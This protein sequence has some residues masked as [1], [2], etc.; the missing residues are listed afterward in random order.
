[1]IVTTESLAGPA[2]A[3]ATYRQ[4][5]G[6]QPIVVDIEDV[7]D[8]FSYG[9]T[10]P[11]AL[12]DFLA[13]A[14]AHWSPVPE[15]VLLAGSGSYDYKNYRG[16]GDSLVP[17]IM[18]NAND[19]LS[20]ADGL[21]ADI[22]GDDGSPELAVGR[23]PVLTPAELEAY[24]AKIQAYE[25]A[26]PTGWSRQVVMLADNDDPEAGYFAADSD[27]V[28]ALVP[29]G[30][31]VEKIYLGPLT[32]TEAHSRTLAALRAGAGVF[33]Y[34][35]HGA[36]DLLAAEKLLTS[37]DVPTLLNNP[38]LPF[39]SA[40]TCLV[41]NYAVPGY[42]SLSM[43]M[44]LQGDGGAIAVFSPTGESLNVDGVALDTALFHELFSGTGTRAGDA[45]RAALAQF[46]AAGGPRYALD[47]FNL[48]GDPAMMMRWR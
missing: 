37:V 25:A 24:V 42:R 7:Y 8:E 9:V 22:V 32:A 11:Q 38:R 20:A 45:T 48:L 29:A 3:L 40:A 5:Q 26:D 31:T 16:F 36:V 12:R 30:Y 10:T 19:Y 39:M 41:G 1:V 2:G 23:L 35:G 18:V 17:P 27:A 44:A 13:Y 15:Y 4:G 14:Y 47:I 28:A 6:L 34:I 43:R 33:N 21:Y 46:A